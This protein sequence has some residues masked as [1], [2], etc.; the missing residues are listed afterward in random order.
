MQYCGA[1]T[2]TPLLLLFG[3]SLPAAGI[4]A[5][6]LPMRGQHLAVCCLASVQKTRGNPAETHGSWVVLFIE[7]RLMVE[8]KSLSTSHTGRLYRYLTESRRFFYPKGAILYSLGPPKEA[9]WK[10]R[11][12]TQTAT[13]RLAKSNSASVRIP[14]V[15][16]TLKF[17]FSLVFSF[18]LF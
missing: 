17:R 3:Y 18:S 4:P 11:S 12:W 13:S 6:V 1:K 7:L 2:V 14:G 9:S 15:P 5:N 10:Q 8:S 16:W